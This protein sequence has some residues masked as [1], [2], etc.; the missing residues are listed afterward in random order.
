[1]NKPSADDV[2]A[3]RTGRSEKGLTLNERL[4]LIGLID[5]G[6]RLGSSDSPIVADL[7]SDLWEL[8]D[9]TVSGSKI[10]RLKPEEG[11]NGFKIL[12]INSETG[13]PRSAEHDLPQ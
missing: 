7:F 1:M 5:E 6:T 3:N 2:P 12:E 9:A 10:D 13:K 11:G 4:A 8:M